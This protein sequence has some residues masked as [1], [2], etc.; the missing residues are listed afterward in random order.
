MNHLTLIPGFGRRVKSFEFSQVKCYAVSPSMSSRPSCE[1]STSHFG[2]ENHA[3]D[4]MHMYIYIYVLY[5]YVIVVIYLLYIYINTHI[6]IGYMY[7]IY[8]NIHQYTPNV[9]IY[10]IHGSYGIYI[11]YIYIIYI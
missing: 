2:M 1:V 10:T 3:D 9:S 5:I 4:R 6:H 11:L 8:G 7:A